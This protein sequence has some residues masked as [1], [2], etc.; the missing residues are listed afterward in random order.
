MIKNHLDRKKLIADF[1][2]EHETNPPIISP[3][4]FFLIKKNG[5]L[6]AEIV[7]ELQSSVETFLDNGCFVIINDENVNARAMEKDG[8]PIIAL[9]A[10]TIQKVLCDACIMMLS[11]EILPDVGDMEACY[12]NINIDEYG[13]QIKDENNPVVSVGISRDYTREALGYMIA[14]LAIH[15]IVYHEIGHHK[16]GHIKKMKEKYGLFYQEAYQ[17]S[18]HTVTSEEY[19]EER[20][21]MELKA[22]SYAANLIVEKMDSLMKPWGE[23]LDI[24]FGYSEMFQLLIPALVI[25]KEN[26]PGDICSIKEFENN[27]Y[28]PNIIRI[29]LT[30]MLVVRKPHIKEIFW[31]DILVMFRENEEFRKQFEEDTGTVVFDESLQMN[32]IVYES[33]L[34]L[35]IGKTEQIYTG[36][37]TGNRSLTMFQTDLKAIYWFRYLYK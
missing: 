24:D 11:D 20:K 34:G 6:D 29:S 19:V 26:L 3:E 10:G 13:M 18:L 2:A 36:I 30:A 23:Y 12:H 25:I 16:L 31:N 8:I 9:Y 21:W 33:Y 5:I 35:M 4:D 32:E 14:S 1:F 15:F 7:S 27:F 22:D 28:F 17:E 37:F